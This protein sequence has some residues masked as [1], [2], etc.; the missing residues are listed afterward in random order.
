VLAHLASLANL[1]ADSTELN[2]LIRIHRRHYA[3]KVGVS[4]CRA[5]PGKWRTFA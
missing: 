1:E 4:V 2:E 3:G 5:T